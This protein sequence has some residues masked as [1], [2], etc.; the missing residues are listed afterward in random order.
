MNLYNLIIDRS[1]ICKNRPIHVKKYIYA[2][3]KYVR[4]IT[5]LCVYYA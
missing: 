2:I 5:L 3:P 1:D 4:L